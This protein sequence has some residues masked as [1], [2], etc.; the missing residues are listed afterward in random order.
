MEKKIFKTKDGSI[1]LHIPEWNEQYHSTHGALTE[2]LYVFIDKGLFYTINQFGNSGIH[3]LE[4]GFGTGLNALLTYLQ[5]QENKWNIEY[6]T[7]EAFPLSVEDVEVLN[8]PEL[9]NVSPETFLNF[10]QLPWEETH[11]I[12][13]NFSF[14]KRNGFFEEIRDIGKFDLVYFDAF[15]IRVQPELWTEENFNLVYR[16]LKP[17]G[18]LVTYAANGRARRAMQEVGFRVERLDGPPGKRQM[19]RAVKDKLY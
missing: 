17:K 2:A 10:H 4:M 11:R 13:E 6:S 16:A 8:Y 1:T 5:S 14:T 12:S 7:I 9:L 15:G 3:I 18:V 19:M